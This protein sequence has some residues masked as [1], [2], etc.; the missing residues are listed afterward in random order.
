MLQPRTGETTTPLLVTPCGP[1]PMALPSGSSIDT[2]DGAI[3]AEGDVEGANTGVNHL[4]L[5]VDTDDELKAM[6]DRLVTA[7][8]NLVEEM[9]A[10]CCYAKSDKYWIIDPQGIAWETYRSLGSIPM[11]GVDSEATGQTAEATDAAAP[12]GCCAPAAARLGSERP[13]KARTGCCS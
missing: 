5:Q 13:G 2:G 6:R 11:F 1:Q 12:A 8:A 10:N 3:Q 9:G 7:D 4:G